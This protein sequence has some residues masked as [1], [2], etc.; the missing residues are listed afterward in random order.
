MIRILIVEDE[1]SI[2]DTLV[3]ALGGEGFATHWVRLGR[4]AIE[5]VQQGRADLVI[6]DVGLPDMSGFEVCKA[7]RRVSEVPILFLTARAE[8]IDRVVGLE[9]GADDYV[10]KPFSP[11]EVAARVRVILKRM[12]AVEAGAAPAAT[13]VALALPAPGAAAAVAPL[14]AAPPPAAPLPA[15]P[16]PAEPFEVDAARKQIRHR[17]VPLELTPHEFRLLAHLLAHPERVFS[18]QQLLDAIGAGS[19]AV[20]ERNIDGHVKALRAKLRTVA[21]DRDPIQTHRGFGYSFQPG[22]RASGA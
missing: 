15:A 22:R 4:E 16:L 18:R 21:P 20:Y 9:I 13:V 11:R 6:L 19:D 7:I 17:G 12:R 10:V 2:A 14:P 8:E 1:M 5:H 3:F